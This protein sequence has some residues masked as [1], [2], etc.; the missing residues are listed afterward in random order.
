MKKFRIAAKNVTD[1]KI[2]VGAIA[3]EIEQFFTEEG[4]DYKDYSIIYTEKKIR[5]I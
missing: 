3:Q 5:F 2:R 4:L 1:G